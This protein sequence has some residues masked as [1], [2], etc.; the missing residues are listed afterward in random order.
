MLTHI[1]NNNKN[2]DLKYNNNIYDIKCLITLCN[3]NNIILNED[4]SNKNVTRDSI[5]KGKCNKKHCDNSFKKK[6][7]SL[8]DEKTFYCDDCLK[9]VINERKITTFIKNYRVDNPFKCETIKKKIKQTNKERYGYEHQMHNTE[10]AEKCSKNAYLKKE[11]IMPSGKKIII[12]GYENFLLDELLNK[13]IK[14]EDIIT[15]RTEVPEIWYYDKDNKE[16]RYYV[17]AY[18]K[19]LNKFYEVKSTWTYEKNKEKIELCKD[20]LYFL[21]YEYEIIIY[22]SKGKIINKFDNNY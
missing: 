18:V 6:L 2:K 10:I 11:Y 20:A 8:H 7:R 13:N 19:S 16:H 1:I 22:S 14:E 3:D 9:N 12:Q 5:I 4:Y 21:G 15:S 17:D